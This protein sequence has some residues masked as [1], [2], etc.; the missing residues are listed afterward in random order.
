VKDIHSNNQGSF[1]YYRPKNSQNN[2]GMQNT[3]PK[4]STNQM[5]NFETF[6]I[7]YESLRMNYENEGISQHSLLLLRRLSQTFHDTDPCL[8]NLPIL[9]AMIQV[10]KKLM[11]ND[12]EILIW[13]IYLKETACNREDF[14]EYLDTSALFVKK[15]LNEPDVFKIFETFLAHN[16]HEIYARYAS[17]PKPQVTLTLRRINFYHMT[18]LAPF[19]ITRDSGIHDFNYEVDA[20]EDEHVRREVH[21]TKIVIEEDTQQENNEKYSDVDRYKSGLSDNSYNDNSQNDNRRGR[22][23]GRGR[24]KVPVNVPKMVKHEPEPVQKLSNFRN[25]RD[26]KASE[27]SPNPFAISSHERQP[28]KK[29]FD[30]PKEGGEDHSDAPSPIMPTN[31]AMPR[32][33]APQLNKVPLLFSQM[34]ASV[35]Q[36]LDRERVEGHRFSFAA[37]N[38]NLQP[39]IP[40]P[41]KKQP[42]PSMESMHGLGNFEN[43]DESLYF[44]MLNKSI[45]RGPHSISQEFMA[46]NADDQQNKNTANSFRTFGNA[47]A[48]GEFGKMFEGSND[49]QRNILHPTPKYHNG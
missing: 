10:C 48:S 24:Q 27:H 49:Q 6:L 22:K 21:T 19:E 37:S 14:M 5:A 26:R 31:S 20:L 35:K 15:D 39:A 13:A 34:G 38:N 1:E 2:E 7:K 47:F 33:N 45:E 11:L 17:S 12:F 23:R 29:S 28:S 4:A 3:A 46:K 36:E 9:K 42:I 44:S 43:Y 41:F 8:S 16:H 25:K 30:W 18:L 40:P 32:T